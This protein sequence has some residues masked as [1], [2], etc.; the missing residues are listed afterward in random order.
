MDVSHAAKLKQATD[1]GTP[2][3]ARAGELAA[4]TAPP[5][6]R[7]HRR[8]ENLMEILFAAHRPA[9]PHFSEQRL[10]DVLTAHQADRPWNLLPHKTA[11]SAYQAKEGVAYMQGRVVSKQP[12]AYSPRT[13]DFG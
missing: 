13:P 1:R 9:G 7:P 11:A 6:A 10:E 2:S 3:N 12:I 5:T 8:C 4:T